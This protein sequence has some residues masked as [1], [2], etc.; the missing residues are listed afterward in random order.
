MKWTNSPA[1]YHAFFCISLLCL[2]RE[3]WCKCHSI[4][5]CMQDARLAAKEGHNKDTSWLALFLKSRWLWNLICRQSAGCF[6]Q[7]ARSDWRMTWHFG[8]FLHF[9]RR[10]TQFQ[11]RTVA[12]VSIERIRIAKDSFFAVLFRVLN[13]ELI[14]FV[15]SNRDTTDPTT[16]TSR[17]ASCVMRHA[18]Q[19]RKCRG[20]SHLLS[21]PIHN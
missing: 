14:K 3:Y 6:R 10:W 17:H 16:Q 21:Q 18:Q 11:L 12:G 15:T 7:E 5:R 1:D 4:G 9:I 8:T 19:E 20:S 2:G 13:V